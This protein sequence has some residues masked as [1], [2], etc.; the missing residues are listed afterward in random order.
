M[1]YISFALC[2]GTYKYLKTFF[3]EEHNELPD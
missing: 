1:K 3:T 2:A